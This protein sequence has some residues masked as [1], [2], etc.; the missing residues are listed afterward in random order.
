MPGEKPTRR[1]RARVTPLDGRPKGRGNKK[2][3]GKQA[4]EEV[5]NEKPAPTQEEKA[6]YR[7]QIEERIAQL[8][9]PAESMDFPAWSSLRSQWLGLM[10]P[11]ELKDLNDE[12]EWDNVKS[13][14]DLLRVHLKTE[15]EKQ[16][17]LRFNRLSHVLSTLKKESP[18]LVKFK[19][20]RLGKPPCTEYPCPPIGYSDLKTVS[21]ELA[22]PDIA[23][24]HKLPLI[25]SMLEADTTAD[26][27]EQTFMSQSSD[28]DAIVT[29]WRDKFHRRLLGF[30]PAIEGDILQP[31]L[32]ADDSDPFKDLSNDMK[33]LLRADSLFSVYDWNDSPYVINSSRGRPYTYKELLH[34]GSGGV[35][36][37]SDL[38]RQVQLPIDCIGKYTEAQAVAKE[39]LKSIS[40]PNAS[41]LELE[42][43]YEEEWICGQCIDTESY[44]W[45]GIVEHYVKERISYRSSQAELAKRKMT[46]R[47]VHGSNPF[48]N[49]PMIRYYSAQVAREVW[50]HSTGE[51][52]V[53]QCQ[54]CSR[55]PINHEVK[56][57]K[58]LMLKHLLEV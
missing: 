44:S 7:T 51:N 12:K 18:P 52:D 40:R 39:L 22:F 32:V 28:I 45:Q 34:I 56:G 15:R 58:K 26:E 2:A 17:E 50:S 5:K 38:Q 16:K 47:D 30:L 19:V 6:A 25:R 8:G 21:Q 55:S 36:R 13:H 27:L 46:F 49:R 33:R 41:Y 57:P 23:D 20:R 11:S 1:G 48:T 4:P 54:I 24:I 9:W 43:D 14:L 31:T 53:T 35:S 3:S 37:L 42:C 10:E 29:E